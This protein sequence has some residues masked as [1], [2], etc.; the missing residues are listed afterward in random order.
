M[1]VDL[2]NYKNNTY[3]VK[4]NVK[5]FAF[6]TTSLITFHVFSIICRSHFSRKYRGETFMRLCFPNG[7]VKVRVAIPK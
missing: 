4:F 6:C 1:H 5:G 7:T 2:D 3:L